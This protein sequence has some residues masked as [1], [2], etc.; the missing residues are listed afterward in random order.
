MQ[1]LVPNAQCLDA[2]RCIVL[3]VEGFPDCGGQSGQA[4]KPAGV[5]ESGCGDLKWFPSAPQNTK[6]TIGKTYIL[7]SR[8][9]VTRPVSSGGLGT[10]TSPQQTNSMV[11]SAR[12]VGI[13]RKPL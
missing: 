12:A 2:T 6:K 9:Q 3:K 1:T 10:S 5:G 11:R 8:D 7:T 13:L 4:A